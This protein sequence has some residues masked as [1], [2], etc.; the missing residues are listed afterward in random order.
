MGSANLSCA[1]QNSSF[2]ARF[3]E[4]RAFGTN[5][6]KFPDLLVLSAVII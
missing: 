6:A 4:I 2:L 1:P 3:A 5:F